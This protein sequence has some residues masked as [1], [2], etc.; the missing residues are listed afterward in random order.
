MLLKVFSAVFVWTIT[1]LCVLWGVCRGRAP[2][3]QAVP[4]CRHRGHH[5]PSL[6]D[7]VEALDNVGSFEPIP[8]AHN[9]EL[10]VNHCHPKLQPPPVHGPNLDPAVGPE[11]VFLNCGGACEKQRQPWREQYPAVSSQVKTWLNYETLKF[12]VW[13]FA[14]NFSSHVN[15]VRK[16]H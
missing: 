10:V 11:V 1:R 13:G 12:C 14:V 8:S 9:V 15:L 16:L 5:G 6:G 4:V 3:T 7:G 2:L